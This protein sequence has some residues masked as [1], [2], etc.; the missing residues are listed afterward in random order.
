MTTTPD[1][2]KLPGFRA[3]LPQAAIIGVCTTLIGASI[4]G[5]ASMQDNK[6]ATNKENAPVLRAA[7]V[8]ERLMQQPIDIGPMPAVKAEPSPVA[9]ST[10]PEAQTTPRI[11]ASP[12]PSIEEMARANAAAAA[13]TAYYAKRADMEKKRV[14]AI[15]AGLTSPMTAKTTPGTAAA[16]PGQGAV[17]A[18]AQPSIGGRAPATGSQH[19]TGGIWA[20]ADSKQAWA[21]QTGMNG[22]DY[23][24]SAR[25]GPVSP[26]E[27]M[28]GTV[29]PAVT[30]GGMI[31][32]APGR[33][34]GQ[35]SRDVQCN[36]PAGGLCIPQ[37]ST[38]ILSYDNRVANGE[39]RLQVAAERLIFPDA[40]SMDLGRMIVADAS[41]YAGLEDEYQTHLGARLLNAAL[42]TTVQGAFTLGSAALGANTVNGQAVESVASEETRAGL[43]VPPTLRVRPGFPFVVTLPKD[44]VF[45]APYRFDD[46]TTGDEDTN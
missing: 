16:G 46:G 22:L 1:T 41:G 5:I 27:I 11:P 23:V 26:Y 39:T 44:L 8:P 40:T 42:F 34:V 10:T 13:W 37:G 3:Y 20:S 33:I 31:S 14:E 12:A 29:L 9:E 2:E 32:D 24:P 18:S 45:E 6:A 19:G 25:H 4:W 17:A 43:R 28:A 30:K 36:T 7:T 15:E 35:V 21:D 38:L